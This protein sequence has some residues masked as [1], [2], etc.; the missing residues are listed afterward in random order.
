MTLWPHAEEP[1]PDEDPREDL[2]IKT[3]QGWDRSRWVYRQIGVFYD[4]DYDIHYVFDSRTQLKLAEGSAEACIEFVR[5]RNKL[6]RLGV[7]K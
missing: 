1:E 5:I 6:T 3:R 7:M 4:S 2:H